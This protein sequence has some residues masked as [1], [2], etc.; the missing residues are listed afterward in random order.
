MQ[1]C[2]R[3]KETRVVNKGNRPV[4]GSRHGAAEHGETWG[5]GGEEALV[6]VLLWT[7]H[8]FL[9]FSNPIPDAFDFQRILWNNKEALEA[10]QEGGDLKEEGETGLICN[11]K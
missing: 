4:D 11:L 2:E 7:P 10:L 9:S 1:N 6:L 5:H 3:D 8:F